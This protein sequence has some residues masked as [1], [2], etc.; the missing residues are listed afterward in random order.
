M[1][2]MKYWENR[3]CKVAGLSRFIALIF[4]S[5]CSL[6]QLSAQ[7]KEIIHSEFVVEP[8]LQDVS[9]DSFCV[10][11]ETS[12]PFKGQVL[13]AKSE[14]HILKPELKLVE[15]ENEARFLHKL[16]VRGLK[17]E[18]LYFYQ[19]VNINAGG[20]TLLG[21]VTQ[22][23][24][25]DFDH[26]AIN[27][28][29]V[30]D[31]Q[32][33]VKCWER[34]SQQMF[35]EAPQFVVHVGDMVS[36]GHHKDDW[37][38]EFFLQARELMRH[39]PLYPAMGNH[40]MDDEKYY[41]Y[42]ARPYD[43]AFYTLKKGDL[44]LI[45]VDTNKDLLTGSARYKRLEET[46]ANCKER[47]KIVIH[48]HPVFTSDIASYRSSL[49]ATADKGDPNIFQMKQLYETYGVDLVLSGHVHGYERSFPISKNHIDKENGVVYI[50]S[51]GGGGGCNPASSYKEWFTAKSKKRMHYLNV[52]IEGDKMKVEAI[53]TSRVVF[54]TWE[55]EKK[56]Q[57]SS[58]I[59]PLITVFPKYFIDST[60]VIIKN[61]NET[62]VVNYKLNDENYITSFKNTASFHIK[63]TSTISALVSGAIM[64]SNE[65]VKTV[66]KLPLMKK[67]N[68][69]Q[70]KVTASYFEG[71]FTVLPDFKDLKS[72][73]IF[74]L[75]SLSLGGIKPRAKDHFAICFTGS[76]SVPETDVY[77]FFL[78][79]FD[80]S[81]LLI[82]GKEIIENDG[83]H[84]EIFKEG[85]AALEK[86]NHD[87]E[88]R[89]FDFKRRET[90]NLRMG[91]QDGEM[92]DIN[93][94]LQNR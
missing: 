81:M 56:S 52:Q 33:H 50:I 27:F 72:V 14:R 39:I 37:T 19:V 49:M 62:G 92:F 57:A 77:R 80:G 61:T 46:L 55:L 94:F 75:D 30:G 67:Q 28:T 91:T 43:D 16:T 90:L 10:M 58:L 6:L 47:W 36:Y 18:E 9:D 13:L 64:A 25:P 12:K 82:D 26:S 48:H 87:I 38:D 5:A 73:K 40:E 15:A 85:Y 23:M 44:A 24:I 83:V 70:K 32:G 1:L 34:I 42:F 20:D 7:E 93:H 74:E 54:D 69:R 53:D 17:A 2:K 79:S 51:A 59:A 76:I 8:Y 22:L 4:I 60:I 31:N 71:F 63:N 65:A 86:G 21:P 29:V 41:Q 45:F 88:V 35:E 68:S 11:W 66:E 78:E 84:Y 89:Y 3:S